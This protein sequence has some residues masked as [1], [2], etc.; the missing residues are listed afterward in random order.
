LVQATA[1]TSSIV[2]QVPFRVTM[3]ECYGEAGG[4]LQIA[5]TEM[6]MGFPSFDC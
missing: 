3:F 4:R 6:E 5:W 1:A 2:R